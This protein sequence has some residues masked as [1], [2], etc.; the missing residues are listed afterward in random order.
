VSSDI[1][2]KGIPNA[3]F[4]LLANQKH[5]YFASAPEEVHGI[6]REFLRD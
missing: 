3:K 5:N 4:A 6:I 1:L 2:A